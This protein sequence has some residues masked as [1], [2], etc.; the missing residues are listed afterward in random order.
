MLLL[1]VALAQEPTEAPP[2]PPPPTEEEAQE[3]EAP[4]RSGPDVRTARLA[5]KAYGVGVG[6]MLGAPTGLSVA[7]RQPGEKYV[8]AGGVTWAVTRA[9]FGVHM[10]YQRVLFLIDDPNAPNVTFPVYLGVG[11]RYRTREKNVTTRGNFAVR[12]PIG[13]SVVPERY[14]VGGF[15]EVAPTF[16]MWPDTG[17]PGVDAF[18]GARVFFS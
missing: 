16:Q 3:T 15:L 5:D 8:L 18:V 4:P 11:G 17:S 13:L 2:P 1:A 14:P 10:D 12:V 9:S 7:S 6:L